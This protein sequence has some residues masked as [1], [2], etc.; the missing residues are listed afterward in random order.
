[1]LERAIRTYATDELKENVHRQ[2][3]DDNNFNILVEQLDDHTYSL[4]TGELPKNQVRS[5][6]ISH[7]DNI[8]YNECVD[9]RSPDLADYSGMI[10]QLEIKRSSDLDDKEEPIM[11]TAVIEVLLSAI[12]ESAEEIDDDVHER[13]F[14]LT[15]ELL[16]VCEESDGT[17][18]D[19]L[20]QKM[21]QMMIQWDKDVRYIGE[22]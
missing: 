8:T 22:I 9:E 7:V 13:L 1:M 12:S 20:F 11:R 16:S 19:A 14:Q 5:I 21:D 2:L 10:S 15:N 6:A 17:D 18:W 3:S 4:I